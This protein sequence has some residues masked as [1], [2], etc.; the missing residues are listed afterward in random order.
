MLWGGHRSS[1]DQVSKFNRGRIVAYGDCELSFREIG[2]HVGRKQ[3]TVMRIYH[4]WTCRA[5]TLLLWLVE[6]E[7]MW[8]APGHPQGFLSLNEGGT[9]QN[10]NITCMVLKAKANDRRKN[11]SP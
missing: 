7:E 6:G 4:R 11:S 9:K 5:S 8:E 3:A 1:F 2:Q 10:R